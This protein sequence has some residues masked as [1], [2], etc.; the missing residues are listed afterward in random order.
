MPT[1]TRLVASKSGQNIHV[2]VDG[3][4]AFTLSP[5]KVFD[6]KINKGL[7]IST[8]RLQLLKQTSNYEKYYLKALNLISYRPRSTYEISSHLTRL[9]VDEATVAKIV[10]TLTEQKYLDDLE[11]A[12][13]FAR[14]KISHKGRGP[15]R[16]KQ[17]LLQK[18]IS[19][20]IISTVTTEI[21]NDPDTVLKLAKESLAKKQKSYANLDQETYRHKA[22]QYL[23]RQGYSYHIISQLLST[24]ID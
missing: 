14:S 21:F 9:L 4:F 24:S 17:E 5:N 20:E 16:I 2:H 11:F 8:A 23:A 13:M 12:T 7:E 3:K 6:Y 22:T 1:I 18:G 10:S 15:Y 19:N